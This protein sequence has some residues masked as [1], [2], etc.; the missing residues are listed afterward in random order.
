MNQLIKPLILIIILPGMLFNCD[1]KK[2]YNLFLKERHPENSIEILV[3]QCP[4]ISFGPHLIK[5]Y[6]SYEGGK[7]KL[8]FRKKLYNDG[9][10]LSARNIR[11]VWE[12]QSAILI[13][14]GQEQKEERWR[15]V[16]KKKRLVVI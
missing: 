8:L 1:T 7:E 5:V 2:D 4:P 9:A 16:V 14:N 10:N 13:F 6:G 12:G 3:Y 15:V 11:I